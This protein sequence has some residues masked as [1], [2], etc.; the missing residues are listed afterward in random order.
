MSKDVGGGR[1]GK[2]A[3]M[4]PN[5]LEAY[6][7]PPFRFRQHKTWAKCKMRIFTVAQMEDNSVQIKKD[8]ETFLYHLRIEAEVGSLVNLCKL[9]F[10]L[11][12]KTLANPQLHQSCCLLIRSINISIRFKSSKCRM[13][14]LVLIRTNVLFS[15]S[16]GIRF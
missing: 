14:P 4:L 3:S 6:A 1:G 9:L 13:Q 7:S 2:S 11:S 15:W 8:L 5:P 16:K 10:S 12:G